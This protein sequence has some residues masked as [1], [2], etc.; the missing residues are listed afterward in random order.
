MEI[1]AEEAE[2][3]IA[4]IQS[5]VKGDESAVDQPNVDCGMYIESM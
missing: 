5:V 2:Q 4:E 1:N 3:L